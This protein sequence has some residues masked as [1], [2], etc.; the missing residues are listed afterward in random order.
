RC[1]P[2]VSLDPPSRRA[3][4]T[5]GLL[6]LAPLR[7]LAKNE[8]LHF[9]AY[10][11]ASLDRRRRRTLAPITTSWGSSVQNY[12]PL[13]VELRGLRALRRAGSS[14]CDEI[15]GGSSFLG[16]L[17]DPLALGTEPERDAFG[18]ATLRA[19]LLAVHPFVLLA[20]RS[21]RFLARA[22]ASIRRMN[23]SERRLS[24]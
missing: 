3:F 13:S 11:N 14:I 9:H 18:F 12:T 2:N 1:A 23:S 5:S 24:A 4:R 8:R 6:T 19:A 21:R 16:G 17:G 10:R 22:I 20:R 7:G 15:N